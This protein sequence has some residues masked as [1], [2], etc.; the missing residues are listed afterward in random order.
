MK[1]VRFGIVKM[2][3]G[4]AELS[5]KEVETDNTLQLMYDEIGCDTIDI[6]FVSQKYREKGIDVV[7]DDNGKLVDDPEVTAIIVDYVN[8]HLEAID[9]I[10]STYLLTAHNNA[11]DTVSLTDEQIDYIKR[12]FDVAPTD[13][14]L[15]AILP[16]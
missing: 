16:Y 13:K 4:K 3:D 6:P 9:L 14:G 12:T 8:G 11:G 5:F 10:C 7:I 15:L 1:K 2:V